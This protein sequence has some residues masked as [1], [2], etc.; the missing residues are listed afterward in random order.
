RGP[1][2]GRLTHGRGSGVDPGPCAAE[3]GKTVAA[4][5]EEVVHAQNPAHV[6]EP[7]DTWARSASATWSASQRAWLSSRCLPSGVASPANSASD[8]PF[9]RS[10]PFNRPSS[11]QR[12]RTLGCRR[13]KN[14]ATTY[15]NGPGHLPGSTSSTVGGTA[16]ADRLVSTHTRSQRWP[17]HIPASIGPR[18]PSAAGVLGPAIPRRALPVRLNVGRRGCGRR[19]G[20]VLNLLRR[21]PRG[22]FGR[23]LRVDR[24][25]RTRRPG[26]RRGGWGTPWPSGLAGR[27]SPQRCVR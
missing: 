20:T 22:V 10:S 18:S 1:L 21:G 6:T 24:F 4:D 27:R 19:H 9:S 15:A 26:N 7:L 2:Q 5:R 8:Q 11:Y 23:R 12:A 14:G 16:T 17:S 13:P 25:G 3:H